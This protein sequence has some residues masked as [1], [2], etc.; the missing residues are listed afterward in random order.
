[1]EDNSQDP[2]PSATNINQELG[3]S[4]MKKDMRFLY[5][6]S[7]AQGTMF[8]HKGSWLR[9]YIALAETKLGIIFLTNY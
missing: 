2:D 8:G 3:H 9:M 4:R 5:G 1:M 6:L 7:S